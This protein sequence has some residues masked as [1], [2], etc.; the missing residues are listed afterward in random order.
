[1]KPIKSGHTRKKT[2]ARTSGPGLSRSLAIM[3]ALLATGIC[4]ACSVESTNDS[5]G[6]QADTTSALPSPTE[7]DT[8][9]TILTESGTDEHHEA[10]SNPDAATD[11]VEFPGWLHPSISDH[12]A[13]R[14]LDGSIVER[15]QHTSRATAE[16]HGDVNLCQIVW[17]YEGGSGI[18]D[19]VSIA[20]VD[21]P[22]VA[23]MD[24]FATTYVEFSRVI[25]WSESA[26]EEL[27]LRLPGGYSKVHGVETGVLAS[28]QEGE[29][30]GIFWSSDQRSCCAG[31]NQG[32]PYTNDYD[33]MR[34]GE[35]DLFQ[36][37]GID[38]Q[39]L[40]ADELTALVTATY[41][42]FPVPF[43]ELIEQEVW[44]APEESCPP[45]AVAGTEAD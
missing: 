39:P 8:P 45:L 12:L 3:L 25:A 24:S 7:T 44:S 33:V 21:E 1:M 2:T 11:P 19:V 9:D 15:L 14:E 23:P 10:G 41:E 22:M 16:L 32:W 18:Y 43:D 40:P 37:E 38:L 17:S 26:P 27:V 42:S 4:A 13:G 34:M 20:L 6:R 29:R 30:V 36:A 5:T 31:S 28:F 35:D